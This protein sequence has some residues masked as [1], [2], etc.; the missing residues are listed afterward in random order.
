[1]RTYDRSS[2]LLNRTPASPSTDLKWFLVSG[3][4]NHGPGIGRIALLDHNGKVVWS[5]EGNEPRGLIAPDGSCVTTDRVCPPPEVCYG[6]N[7]VAGFQVLLPD[8]SLIA[9][10][11]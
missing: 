7:V 10:R 5:R 9:D 3:Q 4:P 11:S 1:V 8:G 2:C 6:E